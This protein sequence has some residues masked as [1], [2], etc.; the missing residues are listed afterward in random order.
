MSSGSCSAW[1]SSDA[2]AASSSAPPPTMAPEPS[3]LRCASFGAMTI[4]PL[5]PLALPPRPLAPP[6]PPPVLPLAPPP[7]PTLASMVAITFPPLA[8]PPQESEVSAPRSGAQ[9]SDECR[10]SR[11]HHITCARLLRMPILGRWRQQTIPRA[12]RRGP[13]Q[14]RGRS[15]E[16]RDCL[17]V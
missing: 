11:L 4:D 10:M 8:L 9:A 5:S 6:P 12:A 2:Q 1:C 3:P 16:P 13:S 15:R 14:S 7:P 17:D